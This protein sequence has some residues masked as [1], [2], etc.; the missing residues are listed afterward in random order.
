MY[1]AGESQQTRADRQEHIAAAAHEQRLSRRDWA[2]AAGY[3][4]SADDRLP[5]AAHLQINGD[6]LTVLAAEVHTANTDNACDD[7]G[8]TIPVAWGAFCA[9][10]QRDRNE[11]E[12]ERNWEWYS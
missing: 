10:C 9:T 4:P 3:D 7:C 8:R 11:L 6:P 2:E 1:P 5:P 12:V